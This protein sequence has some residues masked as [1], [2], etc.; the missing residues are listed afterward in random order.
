MIRAIYNYKLK[1]R[2]KTENYEEVN[3]MSGIGNLQLNLFSIILLIIILANMCRRSKEY[4]PDQKLFLIMIVSVGFL[5]IADSF[6]W[7][8]DGVPGKT[9]LFASLVFNVIGYIF[10]IFPCFLWCL[11]VRYQIKM[12]VKEMLK[13]RVLLSVPFYINAVLSILSCFYSFY[14]YLDDLNV[15]HRGAFFWVSAGINYAYYLYA[16][17]YLIKN[18]RSTERKLFLL[19]SLFPLPPL[20]GSI[21]Q[22]EH[23]GFALLWPGAT[24]SLAIIYLNI[25]KNQL[26][27]DHLTG[28]YNRRLLDI[29]LAD[30]LRNNTRPGSIGVIMIDID[31][32]KDIN[33]MFGHLIGDE[34]LS[35]TA[36]ILK[37]SVGRRGFTA[38]YGGDEFVLVIPA[39]DLTEIERIASEIDRNT[40]LFNKRPN[41]QYSVHL[42][43]GYSIFKCDGKT[44][45]TDVLNGIDKQMYEGKYT[46]PVIENQ[47]TI[48]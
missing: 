47:M 36:S 15:Y 7:L 22:C 33:D 48:Q 44:S 30:C 34:A 9:A 20:L 39:N 2:R 38:R 24:L 40:E 12:D 41:A 46:S 10:M 23:Y 6:T 18:R 25:Q 35:E 26:Y 27:T 45:K 11:Y 4:L 21:I 8:L 32:F 14:F 17:V 16:T 5:I 29:H 13:A 43:M 37:K 19:L 1:V 3:S 31:R 42:S 28:L